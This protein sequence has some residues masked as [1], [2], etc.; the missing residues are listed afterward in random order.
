MRN[1]KSPRAGRTAIAGGYCRHPK[2]HT[3]ST[4]GQTDFPFCEYRREWIIDNLREDCPFTKPEPGWAA[5]A[6]EAEGFRGFGSGGARVLSRYRGRVCGDCVRRNM[7]N[8]I[9][10]SIRLR[11]GADCGV[12]DGKV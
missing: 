11:I 6:L 5:F 2:Y 4:L 9:I 8:P 12:T 3:E 10:Q 7:A 1:Q